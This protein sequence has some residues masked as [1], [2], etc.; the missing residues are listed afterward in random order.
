MA[1]IIIKKVICGIFLT[2]STS[3]LIFA[4]G[5]SDDNFRRI[6]FTIN[7]GA[8][9]G[10]M[11]K[12]FYFMSSNFTTNVENSPT[13]GAGIQYALSPAWSLELGYRHTTIK[14]RNSRFETSMNLF[15]LGNILN[16]NQLIFIN[17]I[18]NHVNPFITLGVGYDL[19]S[20]NGQQEEFN[21]H[22]TSYNGGVGIAYKLSNTMDLFTHYEY[23]L[24][25]N[26]IDNETNGWGA[27]LINT[28]T[29][30]IR[31]NFGKK[32]AIHP[33]WS[34]VPMRIS[35]TNY[36]QYVSQAD[37][38]KELNHRITEIKQR[39]ENKESRYS[40][41]I[42]SLRNRIAQLKKQDK[43]VDRPMASN[44]QCIEVNKNPESAES[45][46]KGHYIQIFASHHLM[47][48]E[49]IK[50]HAQETLK[51]ILNNSTYNITIYHRANFYEVMIGIFDSVKEAEKIKERI[52]KVHE[53]AYVITFPRP[54]VLA[55]DSNHP[56]KKSK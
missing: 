46:V 34:P 25:S 9:L 32:E 3:N 28:L 33:S 13:F 8:S 40:A 41:T 38:I 18:S 49:Y 1:S 51:G 19:F 35:R 43:D 2:L 11:N 39:Y 22:N 23:H 15:H 37:S 12:S 45:L 47:V 4:Q 52:A 6:S 10:D 53:D 17:R 14:G 21:S 29:A 30:G 31:F 27:D 5:F 56:D 20:Y 24:G 42:D 36:D 48:S 54:A 26:S 16:L 55:S 44:I 7:S 50:G